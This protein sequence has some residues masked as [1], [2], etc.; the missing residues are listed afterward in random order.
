[1]PG[2]SGGEMI[3]VALTQAQRRELAALVPE[4]ETLL[5]PE[6]RNRRT[7]RL[8]TAQREQAR[9][10][11]EAALE[12]SKGKARGTL[13]KL[14][15]ALEKG[16]GAGTGPARP[17]ATQKTEAAEPAL[18]SVFQ[19][20]ITLK[21]IEPPIWRTIQVQDQTLASL[22]Q[23]IQNAMGWEDCHLH[24]FTIRDEDYG[25]PS[26]LEDDGDDGAVRDEAQV[27]LSALLGQARRGFRFEYLY[28]FGDS[29]AHEIRFEGMVP[30]E[31]RAVYP[32]CVAGARACPPEDIG[33][34]WGYQEL[35]RGG[36]EDGLGSLEDLGIDDFDPEYFDPKE[37][38]AAM[39]PRLDV[40]SKRPV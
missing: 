3:S 16:A 32:R 23:D 35:L 28:D 11:V 30:A 6:A 8:S 37:T 22:H 25:D 24:Q 39:R 38:T 10:G 5:E 18:E 2:K 12:R 26:M 1:M 19:F 13:A 33:G 36:D 20:T 4:L 34:A 21:D 17:R 31:A 29:W 7:V 27:R 14:A 40:R 9:N 15:A